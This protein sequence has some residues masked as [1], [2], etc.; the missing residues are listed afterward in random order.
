MIIRPAEARGHPIEIDVSPSNPCQFCITVFSAFSFH[1]VE[2]VENCGDYGEEGTA[3]M[4]E[5]LL[6]VQTYH[7]QEFDFGSGKS[8]RWL[9]IRADGMKE[10]DGAGRSSWVAK[11]S[12]S[13]TGFSSL[14]DALS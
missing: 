4:P 11:R 9:R 10:D 3:S 8:S 2:D 13:D 6:R 5:P 1:H 7:V 14:L 12:G